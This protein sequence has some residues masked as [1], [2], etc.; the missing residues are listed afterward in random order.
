MGG[1]WLQGES[2]ST[3]SSPIMCLQMLLPGD[4]W[5]HHIGDEVKSAHLC[6]L[7]AVKSEIGAFKIRLLAPL[8]SFRLQSLLQMGPQEGV[9]V[10]AMG[11]EG[12]PGLTCDKILSAR[13]SHKRLCEEPQE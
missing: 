1:S 4:G 13:R 12:A 8:L 3:S 9:R 2:S 10:R 7:M 5:A 6:S 11:G